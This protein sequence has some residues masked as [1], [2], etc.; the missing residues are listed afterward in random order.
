[1]PESLDR[2][3]VLKGAAASAAAMTPLAEALGAQSDGLQLDAPVP[4]SYELFKAQARDRAHA[5]TFPRRG[6]RK[7]CCRRS[8][9]KNGEKSATETTMRCSP[10]GRVGFR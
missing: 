10:T 8:T 3:T 9:T 6:R 4:F 1:M 5:P 7:R 2:R